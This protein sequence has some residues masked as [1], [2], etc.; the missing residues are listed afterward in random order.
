MRLLNIIAT[1]T[2]AVVLLTAC[3]EDYGISASAPSIVVEGWI[4]D[5]EYP[6][7]ILTKTLPIS[8]DYQT[9]D[10]LEDFLVRWAKVTV[11]DGTDS[12]IL[13]GKFDQGYYPPYIYTTGRLKGVAGRTYRLKV[14][15]KDYL[16]TATTTIPPRPVIDSFRVERV[17]PT[18]TLYQITACFTD[19]PGKNYYQFFTRIGTQSEQFV[20]SYLGSV[21]D[22]ELKTKAEIPVYRGH[23]L[24]WNNYTPY[25]SV[26]DSVAVKFAQ[27][28]E[29]TFHFWDNYTKTQSVS[30]N[31]FLS[32]PTK[33]FSN[34]NGGIGCWYGCGSTI[35]YL[36]VRDYATR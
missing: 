28:D 16:A 10:D 27:V 11:S 31:M 32:S 5:G 8:S 6:V 21:D 14:E 9:T 17:L 7:V 4:E 22:A 33:S 13:T 26:N 35:Y 24:T 23:Q 3:N 36:V 29:T 15:Y 20:A 19:P 30:D 25:F 12:V 1:I 2:T 18:D 34:I